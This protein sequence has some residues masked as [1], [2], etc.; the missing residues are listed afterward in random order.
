MGRFYYYLASGE[1]K[2]GAKIF[3]NF[4]FLIGNYFV[5]EKKARYFLNRS[6]QLSKRIGAQNILGQANYYLG[7]CHRLKKRR[8]D[9]EERIKESIEIFKETGAE[10]LLEQ[11]ID[12]LDTL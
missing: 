11:A 8:P 2:S 5:A 4:S 9:A 7:L 12:T 10:K 3:K 6:I 1:K